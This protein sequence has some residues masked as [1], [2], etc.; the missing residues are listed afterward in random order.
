MNSSKYW[1]LREI[2]ARE[3]LL[4]TSIAKSEKELKKMYKSLAE[5]IIKEA[6]NAYLKM[7]EGKS[8]SHHFNYQ[9]YYELIQT[10][11][12]RLKE[13]GD[14]ETKLISGDM[15]DIYKSTSKIV[16]GA[17]RFSSSSISESRIKEIIN[18]TWVGDGKNWS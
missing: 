2:K 1:R 10:I 11:E 5:D 17:Q 16:E 3:K 9:K 12:K 18:S 8:K 15:T 6:E 4:D 13:L 7:Q 14:K